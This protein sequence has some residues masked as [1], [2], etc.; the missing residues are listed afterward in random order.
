M[1]GMTEAAGKNQDHL[2][3]NVHP[4]R[5]MIIANLQREGSIQ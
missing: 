3:H 2:E 1:G 4:D 5:H